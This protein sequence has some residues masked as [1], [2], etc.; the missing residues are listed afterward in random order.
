MTVRTWSHWQNKSLFSFLC[1]LTTCHC[2]HSPTAVDH[3]PCSNRSISPSH[4]AHG[5]KPAAAVGPCWEG[6]IDSVLLHKPC[7]AYYVGNANNRPTDSPLWASGLGVDHSAWR[8][9]AD[10]SFSCK[11]AWVDPLLHHNHSHLWPASHNTLRSHP[12]LTQ[13][14][15]TLTELKPLL[16]WK[17]MFWQLHEPILSTHVNS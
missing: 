10:A 16:S 8:W 15:R 9:V 14:K 1:M 5:S 6:R 13:L 2:L 3:R 7:S 4:Q 12:T 17:R 11:E